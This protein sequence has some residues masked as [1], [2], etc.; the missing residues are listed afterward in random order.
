MNDRSIE[1]IRKLGLFSAGGF[2]ITTTFSKGGAETFAAGVI[3][4]ALIILFKEKRYGN[5]NFKDPLILFIGLYLVWSFVSCLA[6]TDLRRSFII[7]RDE[8]IFAVIPAM[9]IVLN[10]KE[11]VVKML[12]LLAISAVII[13]I[14]AI[15]QHYMGYD[16]YRMEKLLP[17][18]T[19]RYRV[20]GFFNNTITFGNY[21]IILAALLFPLVE[22]TKSRKYKI[23]FGA[24]SFLSA[25]AALLSYQRGVG[26]VFLGVLA[27]FLSYY[28]G[29]YLKILLPS[30]IIT[31]SLLY[32]FAPGLVGQH[33]SHLK[34][35]LSGTNPRSRY[36]IWK[37]TVS[38]ISERPVFGVGPGN[39]AENFLPYVHPTYPYYHNH[40]HNDYL[41]IAVHTGLPSLALFLGIYWAMLWKFRRAVIAPGPD[42]TSPVISSAVM[43]ATIVFILTGLYES[44]T[45]DLE[46]RIFLY[47]L[48]GLFFAACRHIKDEPITTENS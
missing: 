24:A 19:T 26:L 23:V 42:R 7:F 48:W 3:F 18:E 40:A 43:N 2:F 36:V 27:L 14:Y 34:M 38:M 33:I 39:F 30:V 44:V 4:C 1:F 9:A 46:L 6:G 45:D 32:L 5:I 21:F 12:K 22:L 31:V 28:R 35:E 13:S 47:A 15:I 37:S 16:I 10:S 29:R 11:R 25:V 41:N 20:S 17:I 8:W